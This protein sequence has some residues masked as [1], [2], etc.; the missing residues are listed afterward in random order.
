M[1]SNSG[2]IGTGALDTDP[3]DRSEFVQ[4]LDSQQ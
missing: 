3:A 4:Q 1:A 2:A